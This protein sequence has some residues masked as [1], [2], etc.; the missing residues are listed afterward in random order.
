MLARNFTTALLSICLVFRPSALATVTRKAALCLLAPGTLALAVAGCGSGGS[1]TAPVTPPTTPPVSTPNFTLTASPVALSITKGQAG[2]PLS[3]VATATSGF[4][5]S[6]T[7]AISG[8]PAGVTAVPASLTLVAGIAQSITLSGSTSA[9][10]GNSTL[11]LTGTSGTVSHTASVALSVA[12]QAAPPTPIGI[13]VT[14]YHYDNARDG[15][16]A[17]ETTLTLAN[18]N[19]SAFGLVGNFPVDGKVDA[20][21]LLVSNLPSGSSTSVLYVA[22]EH[23]S[24]YALNAT[25][26]AQIWKTSILGSGET[27]SDS[28]SCGQISPEIGITSTP[29]ID[30]SQGKNGTI[31]VVG[32]SKDNSG[33]Y[34][35]RLHALDLLTGAELSGSPTEVAATYPGT[36]EGSA[37]GTLTFDPGQ[38]AERVGLL[39]LNG[40]IYTAWTS[41]CD[42][43]PYT[44]WVIAY[45]ETTLQ[46]SGVLN[47]TPNGSDGA[48]WMSGFGLAADSSNNIYL[49]D[50]NGTFDPGYTPDGFPS[51]SD[52]GNAILKLSTNPQLT[53]ADYFEPWNT[54]AESA[55]D[56]DLGAGGAMLLPDLTDAS[57]KTRH[58]VVGAGKD[59][60]IYLA[61]RDD[62][63]KINL[64]SPDNS[65]IYQ[66]LPSALPNGAWSGPAFFNNTLYYGGVN[67][68]LRAYPVTNALLAVSPSS[69]SST[70][71]PYP[72][73]T[74][75][76]SANGT[77]NGI[78]WA[79]ESSLTAPG[80]LHAYDASNLD[81]EL[82][83]SNQ[84]ANKRDFFGNGNKFIAPMIANGRVFIGTQNSVA[85]FGLLSP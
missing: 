39:L 77:N 26:G 80:V 31:Y 30:R 12:S 22:T 53:V 43:G 52:Y 44:G 78:L 11:T 23:D 59:Q 37:N 82:Y 36:G 55:I 76:I 3:V 14:T 41:H 8:L 5:G 85:V 72:G 9:P 32:M 50:A 75:A 70:T 56:Q 84:A 42:I 60:T 34:H 51:E 63:G 67:D 24:V 83:N 65:N 17:Q 46:Q 19:S 33:K 71:F 1:A 69:K 27:T 29:V 16:N 74:P 66:Q 18:V 4:S 15:L 62:L 35:Q 47:L 49:L 73:T 54:T 57:G 79:V 2:A 6:V 61:D 40:N 38:Y 10:V 21:P 48:V 64:S 45:N 25:N 20:A 58:L 68:N 28:R 7:V 13:D 81:K